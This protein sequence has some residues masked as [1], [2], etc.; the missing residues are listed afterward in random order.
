MNKKQ[1]IINEMQLLDTIKH[2][3]KFATR[4]GC[5]KCW[6]RVSYPHFRTMSDICWKL[7]NDGYRIWTEVEFKGGG[8]ADI[9]A[10]KDGYGFIVEVLHT[11]SEAKFSAKLDSYPEDFTIIPIRT[12]GFDIKEFCL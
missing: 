11:E 12:K 9:I 5:V 10:I 2:T 7:A 3:S 6:R 4:E 1:K 8:R